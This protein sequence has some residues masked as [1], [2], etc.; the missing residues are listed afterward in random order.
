MAPH[1]FTT[2]WNPHTGTLEAVRTRGGTPGTPPGAPAGR[3]APPAAPASGRPSGPPPAAAGETPG[4]I[5]AVASVGFGP[6]GRVCA[7]DVREVPDAVA[8]ALPAPS[9]RGGES[10]GFAWLDSGWLWIPLTGDRPERH[11]SGLADVRIRLDADSVTSLSLHF[12]TAPETGS[13]P[14]TVPDSRTDLENRT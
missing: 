3:P 13:G 6:G 2:A 12:V 10:V 1:T 14:E 8:P 11:R 4:G 7:V 9:R 5:R